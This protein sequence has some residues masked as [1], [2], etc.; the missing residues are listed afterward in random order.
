MHIDIQARVFNLTEALHRF[1]RRR[2]ESSLSTRYDQ[3]QRIRVRL[4]DVN[5]PRGGADKRCQV[6]VVLPNV[7]DVIIEDTSADMYTAI[8]RAAERAG[9]TL[10]RRFGRKR[11]RRARHRQG[12]FEQ[13]PE[14]LV[15]VP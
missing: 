2:L 14:T 1:V 3:I 8:S 9:R 4:S 15:S 10:T 5:G 7:Q 12:L 11:G 13:S 6:H